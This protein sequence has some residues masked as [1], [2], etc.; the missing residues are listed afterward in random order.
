MKIPTVKPTGPGASL[1]RSA[2][3]PL[4][5]GRCGAGSR[6][7]R[8]EAAQ[9]EAAAEPL[10][11]RGAGCGMGI[12]WRWS[13]RNPGGGQWVMDSRA[14]TASAAQPS[15]AVLN[16]GRLRCSQFRAGLYGFFGCPKPFLILARRT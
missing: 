9:R 14:G 16:G 5:A 13:L 6:R 2:R 7:R 3:L 1:P 15:P 4:P 11:P 10:Q 12:V 8:P